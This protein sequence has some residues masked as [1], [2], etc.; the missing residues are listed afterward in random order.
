MQK[1]LCWFFQKS[2]NPASM[3]MYI[4][5][6]L[7]STIWLY[8][9]LLHLHAETGLVA[10]SQTRPDRCYTHS[11]MKWRNLSVLW[12]S[13]GSC[14]VDIVSFEN[15]YMAC[16]IVITVPKVIKMETDITKCYYVSVHGLRWLKY[17]VGNF[18]CVTQLSCSNSKTVDGQH[19]TAKLLNLQ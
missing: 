7:F 18:W 15:L 16:A 9:Y 2:V 13:S 1:M 11:T 5:I 4:I 17:S 19:P 10:Q 12:L 14:D 8:N 3:Y 6:Q